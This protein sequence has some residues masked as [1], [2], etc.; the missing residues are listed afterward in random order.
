MTPRS[1]IKIY[2]LVSYLSVLAL[3]S[4]SE[5]IEGCNIYSD[6][7]TRLFSQAIEM[8]IVPNLDK[9]YQFFLK[10]DLKI[11]KET[12]QGLTTADLI[13]NCVECYYGFF[14]DKDSGL[15]KECSMYCYACTIENQCTKDRCFE[16]YMW[17]NDRCIPCP[18]NC[19]NCSQTKQVSLSPQKNILLKDN[20]IQCDICYK[21]WYYDV[22][23]ENCQ[24]C[25]PGCSICSQPTACD[26]CQK[27]YQL[28][29]QGEKCSKY[30]KISYEY[31]I[32]MTFIGAFFIVFNFL[33]YCVIICC[34]RK[35]SQIVFSDTQKNQ[36]FTQFNPLKSLNI[37]I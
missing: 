9:T 8:K 19:K 15:C 21:G 10:N 18:P 1:N 6:Q 3:A 2:L 13:K 7:I 31:T 14:L 16:G 35:Q 24:Q 28:K 17:I 34:Y 22:V 25:L 37:K 11:K 32:V 30:D 20:K 33:W 26:V 29:N 36:T 23:L 12:L 4:E 5:Y 27:G